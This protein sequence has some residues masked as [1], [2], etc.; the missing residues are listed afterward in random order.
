MDW[1][2]GLSI[3]SRLLLLSGL[4]AVLL[5]ALL[6]YLA[7]VIGSN[8]SRLEEQQASVQTQ[9]DE[10]QRWQVADRALVEFSTMRFWLY[11]LQVSWLNE[12]E[13]SAAAAHQRLQAELTALQTHNMDVGNMPAQVDE[14]QKKMLAAVDAYVD[15]NRVLGNSLVAESRSIASDIGTRLQTLQNERGSSTLEKAKTIAADAE[16]VQTSSAR[17]FKLSWLVLVLVIAVLAGFCFL[18]VRSIS[19]PIKQLEQ[20]IAEIEQNSDLSHQI[21]MSSRDEIGSTASAINRMLTK[22]HAIVCETGSIA[23]QVASKVG[24]TRGS[25]QHTHQGIQDQQMETDQVASA[26]TQMSHTIQDVAKNAE[27]ASEAA[28]QASQQAERGRQAVGANVQTMQALAKEVDSAGDVVRRVAQDSAQI[29]RVVEVIQAISDQTNLLALNAAIEAARAGDAGRGFAVVA[30]EVRSLAQRTRESTQEI[31]DMI[32]RLRQGVD[33]AMTAMTA[34]V[35]KTHGAAEQVEAAGE[36][37][38]QINVSVQHIQGLNVQ[39]AS[40]AEEQSTVTTSIARSVTHIRDITS[41]TAEVAGVTMIA[42][43]EL[44]ALT[45]RLQEQVQQF[46]V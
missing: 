40:A 44:E 36:V 23:K 38:D 6:M 24:D 13:Q 3:R 1:L 46:R 35:A 22:F 27:N 45:I 4:V 33:Q 41:S 25:M 12:S 8:S 19:R 31:N 37:L 14:F 10:V 30:D 7:A 26:V 34:G 9:L 5:T 16:A 39:I 42:C 32:E 18:L 2:T 11:D 17:L 43:E 20:A 29:G 15:E 28:Q 21:E